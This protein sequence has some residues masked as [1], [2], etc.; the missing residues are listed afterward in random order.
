MF[1][2]VGCL[3]HAAINVSTEA[4]ALEPEDCF[5]ELL[6]CEVIC[7]SFRVIS[8]YAGGHRGVGGGGQI[9]SPGPLE[10]LYFHGCF[11]DPF[12]SLTT[13]AERM[14]CLTGNVMSP[15]KD[16]K[17]VYLGTW[18]KDKFRTLDEEQKRHFKR[19]MSKITA[20][21]EEMNE[22][23]DEIEVELEEKAGI[24]RWDCKVEK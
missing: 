15:L 1:R 5:V 21:L 13:E 8:N 22:W 19:C 9:C 17:Y 18:G 11:L 7:E 6:D 12:F 3:D 16:M 10:K 20:Y 14:D 4:Y 23:V 2:L 24:R